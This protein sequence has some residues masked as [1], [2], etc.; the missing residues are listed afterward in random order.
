MGKLGKAVA[1]VA[2]GLLLAM[3]A[4]MAYDTHQQAAFD[5]ACA[6]VIELLRELRGQ[7]TAD[8]LEVAAGGTRP[9][10]EWADAAAQLNED[11]F[12]RH[13][14]CF[15]GERADPRNAQVL[16]HLRPVGQCLIRGDYPCGF[17]EHLG[18]QSYD[19][20][21][22]RPPVPNGGSFVCEDGW[23]SYARTSQGACSHH[24][25]IRY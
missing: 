9:L 18:L 8:I 22:P 13:R 5:E 16:L 17:P 14:D 23:I 24:G 3:P 6:P 2:G 15:L 11:L 20:P 19:P 10:Q 25:G 7:P 12:E 21:Q 1:V 4:S